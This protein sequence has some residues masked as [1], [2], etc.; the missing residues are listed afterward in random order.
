VNQDEVISLLAVGMLGL[1]IISIFFIA[2]IIK[3]DKVINEL[4]KEANSCIDKVNGANAYNA[5]TLDISKVKGWEQFYNT[6]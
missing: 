3:T 2:I 5:P 6:T 4:V 1:V